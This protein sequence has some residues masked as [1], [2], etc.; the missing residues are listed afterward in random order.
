[1]ART[2]ACEWLAVVVFLCC[3]LRTYSD[4]PDVN[5]NL[6][7]T[8]KIEL[9]CAFSDSCKPQSTFNTLAIDDSTHTAFMYMTNSPIIVKYNLTSRSVIEWRQ[10]SD[11]S[12]RFEYCKPSVLSQQ[13]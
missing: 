2:R 1:M 12:R 11:P 9:A 10:Y 5:Y 4:E 7:S 6:V 3:T 13:L 8:Y